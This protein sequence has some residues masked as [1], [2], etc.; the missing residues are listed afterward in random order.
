MNINLKLTAISIQ[1]ISITSFTD[2][3]QITFYAATNYES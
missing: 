3:K 1:Q 2:G